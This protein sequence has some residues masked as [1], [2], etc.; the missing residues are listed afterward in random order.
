M[1]YPRFKTIDDAL[2]AGYHR[3]TKSNDVTDPPYFGYHFIDA[4][5][6]KSVFVWI[7]N[8][9]NQMGKLGAVVPMFPPK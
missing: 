9:K 8:E 7:E 5:G 6:N 4:E 3:A 2:D 1:A